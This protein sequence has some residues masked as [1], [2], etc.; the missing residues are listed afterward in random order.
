[1]KRL[2]YRYWPLGGIALL[3][4]V[5]VFYLIRSEAEKELVR[6][7]VLTEAGLSDG[8]TLTDIHY[9]QDDP[10]QG[11]Q[12]ILNAKEVQYSPDRSYFS[13]RSFHLRLFPEDRPSLELEGAQ[14]DFNKATGEIN[15][16]G[17]LKG[18]SIDGYRI[19]AD[20]LRY[21]HELGLL[22]TEEPVEIRGPFF[23]VKGTGLYI[24]LE[25][26]YLRINSG[27]KTSL[28]RKILT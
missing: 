26:E 21:D 3:A 7:P 10:D 9:T 4:A 27:A 20:H 14:G 2:L 13:F 22:T 25:Q 1:M 11:I 19:F 12:W 23:T 18:H 16:R 24:N 5:A 28:D 8:I 15:L 17:D 6:R